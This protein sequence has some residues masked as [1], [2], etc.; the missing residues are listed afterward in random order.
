MIGRARLPK[1]FSRLAKDSSICRQWVCDTVSPA[2]PGPSARHLTGRFVPVLRD[3]GYAV[4]VLN[5]AP[6]FHTLGAARQ[7]L[8][9]RTRQNHTEPVPLLSRSSRS[10][11][12]PYH[13]PV[14]PHDSSRELLEGPWPKPQH[15]QARA[16]D[17]RVQDR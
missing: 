12:S 2:E 15:L 6:E 9:R 11:A 13:R 14:H 17:A 10:G 5:G 3:Q 8:P 16:T 1:V 7:A 4:D